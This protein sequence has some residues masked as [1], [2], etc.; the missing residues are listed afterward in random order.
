MSEK[1][2]KSWFTKLLIA[3]I[4]SVLVTNGATALFNSRVIQSDTRRNTEA[5]DTYN[6][7]KGYYV[8]KSENNADH[9]KLEVL[10]R[11]NKTDYDKQE[12]VVLDRVIESERFIIERLDKMNDNI[13][14]LHIP[15]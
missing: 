1:E 4:L 2:E 6:I 13:L 11:Q 10:I 8:L 3:A 5:I 12:Q 7:D 9:D 15:K 14:K